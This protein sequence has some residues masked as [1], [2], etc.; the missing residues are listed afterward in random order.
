MRAHILTLLLAYVSTAVLASEWS[1]MSNDTLHTYNGNY[2]MLYCGS[3]QY[4]YQAKKSNFLLRLMQKKI[5]SV[6]DDIKLGT[7]SKHGFRSLFKTDK[8][9]P[10]VRSVFSQ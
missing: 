8:Y 5:Q 3:G 6:F 2:L 1:D 10:H 7:A 4:R 9:Q